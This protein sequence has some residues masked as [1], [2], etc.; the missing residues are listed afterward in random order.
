M[1]RISKAMSWC[2]PLALLAYAASF[3]ARSCDPGARV[4]F[5]RPYHKSTVVTPV[6]LMFGSEIVEV[7]AAPAGEQGGNVGHYDLLINESAVPVGV[8]IPAGP[9]H[10]RFDGG[11]TEAKLDLPPGKYKL[12]LQFADGQNKSHGVEVSA[13]IEITVVDRIPSR[14]PAGT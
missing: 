1:T 5:V 13:S 11:E 2:V 8:A 14:V 9:Q 4:F 7:K 3:P 10:L 6:R 12:T